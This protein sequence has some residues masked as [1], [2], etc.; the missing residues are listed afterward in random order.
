MAPRPPAVETDSPFERWR[1]RIGLGLAVG[2]FVLVW[3]LPLGL[4]APAH[5]AAAIAAMTIVLWITEAMPLAVAALLGPCLAVVLDVVPA[6]EALAGFSHPLIFLFLG[7]FMLA[8]ALSVQGFD[9][10]ATLWLLSRGFIAGIPNRAR[11]AIAA[12]GF[13]FSMFVSNTATTA[14]LVPIAM[15][16]CNTVRRLS[17]APGGDIEDPERARRAA[18]WD[19]SLLL[20]L[21]YST[22]FGGIATPIGTVP[23]ML[24]IERL[25]S[26]GHTIDFLRWMSFGVPTALLA[27]AGMLVW[28]HFA[29]PAPLGHVE[30]L[31]QTVKD[32][33]AAM[34]PLTRGER[35]AL[36]V[37]SVAIAGWIAPSALRLALG[38][39]HPW[40]EWSTR[41]LDEGVVSIVAASALFVIPGNPDD[42]GAAPLLRWERAVLLDWGTLF[43]LGGGFALSSM[44]FST[45][46]AAAIAENAFGR[47]GGS[48]GTGG[49]ALFLLATA[50]ILL[51]TEVASN[52]ATTNMALPVLAPLAVAAGSDPLPLILCVTFAASFAFMLPVSTPPNAIVYGTGRVPLPTM[53]RFGARMDLW[54]Y[55]VLV[56]IGLVWIPWML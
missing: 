52:T 50:A 28:A 36:L 27:F 43:L 13:T 18:A 22:S 5:R 32:E 14:M 54:G 7:G 20:V 10:R 6:K 48:P 17:T 34:G 46:L 15:G 26:M 39:G 24:A 2:V 1:K 41:A 16:L 56:F 35:R 4:P 45:G 19:A 47:S 8:D 29:F 53:I 40:H 11:A 44:V 55:V 30:G 25:E 23:N 37:F 12:I 33:L 31:T 21:A 3:S 51:L 38:E 9:R 42:G 49:L